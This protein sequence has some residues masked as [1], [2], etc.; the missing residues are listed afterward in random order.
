MNPAENAVTI[1]GD[2]KAKQQQKQS[3]TITRYMRVIQYFFYL[4]VFSCLND[5]NGYYLLGKMPCLEKR[6]FL[7]KSKCCKTLSQ[8][9]L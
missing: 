6:S 2:L 5:N 4:I 3:T 9:L 1:R 7:C 8:R